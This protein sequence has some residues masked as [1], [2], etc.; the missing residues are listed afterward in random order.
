MRPDLVS[1]L[2]GLRPTTPPPRLSARSRNLRCLRPRRCQQRVQAVRGRTPVIRPSGPVTVANKTGRA[3][4]QPCRFLPASSNGFRFADGPTGMKRTFKATVAAFVFAVTSAGWVAAG[5]FEAAVAAYEN[6]VASHEKG[7]NATALRLLRPLAEQGDA[8]AQYNLGLMF[9]KG[10]G[11]PQDYATALSW[12]RKAAEQGHAA[13]QNNLGLI[14]ANGGPGVPQDFA[15]AVS[16]Y[17]KAAEQGHAAAQYNL[18]ATYAQGQG[19][20]QDY[21][22]AASWY[23][24][25]AEQGN[26]MAQ[27]NL[28]VMYDDGQGVPQDYAVAV[29][30]YRKA[31]EQGYVDAQVNLG[32]LYGMGQG[33]PRDYVIAHMWFNLAAAGGDKDA[34]T[35]RDRVA[36]QMTPA[37]V[38]KALKLARE[39]KPTSTPVPPLGSGSR[40]LRSSDQQLWQPARR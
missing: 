3:L 31:A 9:D 24:K 17:R 4:S 38:T 16:W 36:A 35:S 25:A 27:Y 13:A 20:S 40:L 2:Y 26:A 28:G 5:P 32:I 18:G 39:W 10:Q 14:F 7:V 12:Y 11:V 1:Q 15:T 6:G 21:G 8:S 19:V 34:V 29:S 30:W 22:A 23:R 33:V 37:Q